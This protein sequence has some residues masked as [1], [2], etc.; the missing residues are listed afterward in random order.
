MLL[1]P[2]RT[3]PVAPRPI[4]RRLLVA[5]VALIGMGNAVNCRGD[6]PGGEKSDVRSTIASAITGAPDVLPAM[7]NRQ[8]PFRYP[9][10]LYSKRVQGNV[11]LRLFVDSTGTVLADSTRVEEGSGHDALDSAAVKGSRDLRFTPARRRGEAIAVSLLY[12]V[13][14]RHPEAEPLPGDT[15][16]K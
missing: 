16:L 6:N 9:A 14:F 8:P 15:V 10:E 7:A 13:Y 11:T 4:I 1:R 2:V 3:P 12:P 5:A